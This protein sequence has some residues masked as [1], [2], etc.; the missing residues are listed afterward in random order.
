VASERGRADKAEQEQARLLRIIDALETRIATIEARA[1]AERTRADVLDQ[2]VG[3][4]RA[5]AAAL[6]DK[7]DELKGLLATILRSQP[8]RCS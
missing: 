7:V 2:A 5:R 3:T 8:S 4:E 6:S 1:D